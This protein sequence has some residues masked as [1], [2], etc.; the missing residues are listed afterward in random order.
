[1]KEAEDNYLRDWLL[2]KLVWALIFFFL[3]MGLRA[4][5]RERVSHYK[6]F[7]SHQQ[8]VVRT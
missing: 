8:L 6:H 4:A 3:L 5:R 1:M 7:P 2:D